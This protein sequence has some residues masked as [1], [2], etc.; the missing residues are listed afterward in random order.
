MQTHA[1]SNPQPTAPGV[2]DTIADGLTLALAYP[3]V[4]TLPILLDIYFWLGWRLTPAPLVAPIRRWIA[5]NNGTGAKSTLDALDHLSRSDMTTLT[6]QF[7]PALLP[8]IDRGKVYELWARPALDLR[9][10]WIVCLAFVALVVLA[11]GLFA[12]YYV[13]LADVAI[14]RRR[15]LRTFPAAVVRT[16]LR[17]LAM[18]VLVLGLL[19]LVLGPLAVIW[20]L[21]EVVGLG[22]GAVLLPIMI[23]V[24]VGMGLFL[25]F[26]PEAIVVADV[27]PFRAMYYSVNVVRRN[28]RQTVGLT[29]ASLIINLGLGEIWQRMANNPPGLM[30]AVIANAF[31]AGG[32]AMAGMIFFNNRLRR[33]PQARQVEVTGR[34]P[35]ASN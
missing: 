8:G 21:A 27:G 4:M 28:T 13:P 25:I 15:P 17:F 22:L 2:I 6:A 33:L 30:I 7:V 11:A 10:W 24:G 1:V 18:I 31:F 9:E 19:L 29:A 32:I 16:W 26:T 12:A 20:G 14:G 3:L 23:F 5:E 35:R 34:A